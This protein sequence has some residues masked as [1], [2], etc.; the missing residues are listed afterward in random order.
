QLGNRRTAYFAHE[1][2]LAA[3]AAAARAVNDLAAAV[4]DGD[5][6]RAVG[7]DHD[8]AGVAVRQA[9]DALVGA[10]V[11]AVAQPVEIVAADDH[12]VV[13]A[14]E[15]AVAAVDRDRAV[16]A[17]FGARQFLRRRFLPVAFA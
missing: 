13:L 1:H 15:N 11:T 2:D 8:G 9:F 7:I 14:D 3:V 16:A 17:H 12:A 10:S 5:D 6:L 4:G